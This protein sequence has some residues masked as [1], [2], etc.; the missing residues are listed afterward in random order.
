LFTS[1]LGAFLLV[2]TGRAA[3]V[4]QQVQSQTFQLRYQERKFRGILEAAPDAMVIV[5]KHQRIVLVNAQ[6]EKLFAYSREELLNQDPATLVPERFRGK[7]LS[8][9]HADSH[10]VS[11]LHALRKDGSELP[12]AISISPLETEEGTLICGAIRDV[13]A[14]RDF[15]RRILA[16]LKEKEVLLK[17]IH[18]RVKNNL[19]VISS[20]LNLQ[21]Q[22]LPDPR[23]RSLFAESQAR[24]QSIALVHETL[25]Q[26]KNLSH[27][28]FADY[29]RALMAGLSHAGNADAR[30][31]RSEVDI[32]AVEVSVDMAIPCGLIISELVTNAL[33]Y[34]FPEGRTGSIAIRL[35]P[36]G[37][38]Q[39]ELSVADDGIGLPTE[40]DPRKTTS[41]GLDLVFTFA[42]QLGAEVDVQRSG[43]LCFQ[44]RFAGGA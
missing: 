5:D 30:G 44:F 12:I 16:S 1:L 19:Q 22:H 26:A 40:L 6:A 2:V 9:P 43:G 41:L 35:A 39:I 34:A 27:V 42:D 28:N 10:E 7:F 18:H 3:A 36:L 23:A 33:K 17:E 11:D 37:S 38:G 25:Y 21:A 20:L 14:T 4:E 31:I 8:A 13:S 29:V 32:A 24:V 15:E